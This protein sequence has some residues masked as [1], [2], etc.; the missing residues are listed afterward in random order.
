METDTPKPKKHSKL[1]LKSIHFH[2]GSDADK[3]W[4]FASLVFGF[5]FLLVALLDLSLFLKF[6]LFD[7]KD[8][9]TTT[10]HSELID[11]KKLNSIIELYDQKSIELKTLTGTS[12]PIDLHPKTG[13]V[14]P[15]N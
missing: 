9:Q 5:L 14:D 6:V 12:T 8:D 10:P 11:R 3:D 7:E 13:I 15:S 2:F 1:D 4:R